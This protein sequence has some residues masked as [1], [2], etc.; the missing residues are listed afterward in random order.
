MLNLETFGSDGDR[1]RASNLEP[2]LDVALDALKLMPTK[3]AH[4]AMTRALRRLEDCYGED[5]E[6]AILTSLLA[7][8]VLPYA[9]VR[10]RGS[11][12]IRE[13]LADTAFANAITAPR[14]RRV[15]AAH[16]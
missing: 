2:Q 7:G 9:R 15:L 12:E 16:L 14:V 6:N 8:W 10:G 3:L 5:D 1:L 11:K 4:R 13:V